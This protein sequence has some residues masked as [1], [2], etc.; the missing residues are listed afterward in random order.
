MWD[1]NGPTTKAAEKP[2]A[3]S[4][5]MEVL[6]LLKKKKGGLKIGSWKWKLNDF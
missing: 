2:E 3:G 6:L 4:Q 1:F 5:K